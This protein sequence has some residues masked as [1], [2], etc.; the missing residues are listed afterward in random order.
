MCVIIHQPKGAYLTK[1]RA[2][3]LW[4]YNSDGGGYAFIDDDNIIQ[5]DK[6]MEFETFWSS[7]ERA[8]SD[9]PQR[10]FLLHMRIATHGTTD[11]TNVHPFQVD[12]ETVVVHNGVFSMVPE[13]RDGRSDTAV[14]VEE[15]LKPM[16]DNWLNDFYMLDMMENWVG[17]NKLAFLTTNPAIEENVVIVNRSFGSTADGMWFSSAGGVRVPYVAPEKDEWKNPIETYEDRMA[18]LAPKALGPMGP[19][20]SG[21]R[22]QA[23]SQPAGTTT[24]SPMESIF[25]S[26]TFRWEGGVLVPIKKD[27]SGHSSEFGNW[28]DD[29][30]NDVV[31]GVAGMISA[32]PIDTIANALGHKRSKSEILEERKKDGNDNKIAFDPSARK[33]QCMGCDEF[34]DF[35]THD[36][37]DG[38]CACWEKVCTDCNRFAVMCT[39]HDGWVANPVWLSETD[40]G[41]IAMAID[42]YN[43]DMAPF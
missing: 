26:R 40:E 5:S 25:G 20:G 4:T 21:S 6:S 43:A 35:D 11:L 38:D 31:N 17:Y 29:D 10:D 32:M 30:Y 34:L 14:F 27:S 19:N 1:D 42:A 13:Y 41:G 24:T 18:R 9:F 15:V 16:P 2:L 36:L 12:D 3:R 33:W 22:T 23:S 7:F 28:L 39:C 8:R 37:L